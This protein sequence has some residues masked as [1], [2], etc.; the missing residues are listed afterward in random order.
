MNFY[1]NKK[2]RNHCSCKC[3]SA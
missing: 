3:E 2:I 1:S